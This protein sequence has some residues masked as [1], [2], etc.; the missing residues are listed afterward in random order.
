M[1]GAWAQQVGLTAGLSEGD[2]V[3]LVSRVSFGITM[4]EPSPSSASP[5]PSPA[6]SWGKKKGW[7]KGINDTEASFNW[8]YPRSPQ[9]TS[10]KH[11]GFLQWNSTPANHMFTNSNWVESQAN[12]QVMEMQNAAGLASS[13]Y[14]QHMWEDMGHPGLQWHP[15]H[16]Q[17]QTNHNTLWPRWAHSRNEW[18]LIC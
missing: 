9:N 1:A 2:L 17:S 15:G 16:P 8:H 13:T 7:A 4:S 14:S 18:V 6:E 10:Y 12:S 3:S 5:S 11:L